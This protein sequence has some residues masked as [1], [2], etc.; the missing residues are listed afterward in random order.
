MFSFNLINVSCTLAAAHFISL[1]FGVTERK[2][3]SERQKGSKVDSLSGARGPDTTDDSLARSNPL[4]AH[5][6]YLHNTMSL[7]ACWIISHFPSKRRVKQ[8]VLM[9][10]RPAVFHTW[11]VFFFVFAQ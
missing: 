5:L 9:I 6:K 2:C 1:L 8:F 3:G 10:Y 11:G 7:I 4:Q